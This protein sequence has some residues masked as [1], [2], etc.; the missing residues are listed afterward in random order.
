VN[1]FELY[2]TLNLDDADFKKSLERVERQASSSSNNMSRSFAAA[3][4]AL[5][6]AFAAVG[7]G[8]LARDII[9]TG[10]SFEASMQGVLAVTAGAEQSF[11]NLRDLAAELGSTTAFSA[12]QAAEGI[13]MLGRNGLTASQILDG[14]AEA[15]LTLAAATGTDLANAGNIA[16][17]VMAAF[18]VEANE[19]TT[20]INGITGVTTSSKFGIDDYRL[21]LANAGGVAGSVGVELADFNTTI[22]LLSPSF[23][24]GQDA[25]TAF[26]TMLQRL[27]PSSK[28]AADMMQQ[29]GLNFQTSTHLWA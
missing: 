23:S 19:L 29:L 13:E 5:T 8:A 7:V 2:G 27:N 21:A 4:A 16:T 17:D 18:G 15:S 20:V 9:R 6:G 24:S 22:A 11:A 12:S 28:E 25:G 26:K 10:A 3:G 1:V 14:A